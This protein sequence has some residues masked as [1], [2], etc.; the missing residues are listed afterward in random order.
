MAGIHYKILNKSRGP[1]V[2]V[3]SGNL[4]EFSQA[5]KDIIYLRDPELK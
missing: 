5:F 3:S 2:Y 1:A 4:L